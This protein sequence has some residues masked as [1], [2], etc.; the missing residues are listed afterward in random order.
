MLAEPSQDWN[1]FQQIFVDH[2]DGFK[3]VY[4]RYNTHYYDGLVDNVSGGLKLSF[5]GSAE[6]DVSAAAS[7][8]PK[9]LDIP[10]FR[11]L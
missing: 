6:I 2:W 8:S 3:H 11:L 9:H 1:V 7:S 10:F 5:S 4:P